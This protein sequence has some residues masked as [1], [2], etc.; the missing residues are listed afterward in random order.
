MIK[1]G[2]AKGKNVVI[3]DDMIQSGGTMTE[4]AKAL[5]RQGAQSVSAF[6]THGVFP[7]ESYKRFLRGGDRAIFDRVWVTNSN[8]VRVRDIPKNDNIE[9][10]DISELIIKDL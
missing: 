9:V 3:V 7:Q 10:L 2:N 4:C 6:C 5:K 8:P 1:D